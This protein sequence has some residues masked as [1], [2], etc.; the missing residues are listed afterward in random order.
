MVAITAQ[1]TTCGTGA[2]EVTACG[3]LIHSKLTIQ[4]HGKCQTD[5]VRASPVLPGR[6]IRA[7]ALSFASSRAAQELDNIIAKIQSITG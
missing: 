6:L 4:G 7:R 1:Q 3:R 5:E 2:F